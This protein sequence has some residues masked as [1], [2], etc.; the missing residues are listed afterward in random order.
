MG[1]VAKDIDSEFRR[2]L[3]AFRR[4]VQTLVM[5]LNMYRYLHER[6]ADYLDELNL[7]PA[8]FQTV[9]VALRTTWVIRGH[10]LL[11]GGRWE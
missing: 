3:S 9:F 8:F 4:Q 1:H 5:V 6:R 2:L 11:T 10:S 7:A